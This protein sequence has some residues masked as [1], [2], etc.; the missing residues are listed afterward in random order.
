[1]SDKPISIG[2][3][4]WIVGCSNPNMMQHLGKIGKALFYSSMVGGCWEVEGA[5]PDLRGAPC[6]W[7]TKHLRRIDPNNLSEDLPTKEEL[8][9]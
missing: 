2:D 3:L 5:A 4:V 7:A 8:S 1:M 9:V 6:L